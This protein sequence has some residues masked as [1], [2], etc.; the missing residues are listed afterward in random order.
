MNGYKRKRIRESALILMGALERM[1]KVYEEEQAVLDSIPCSEEYESELDNQTEIVGKLEDAI[2]RLEEALETLSDAGFCD[3]PA[4]KS[5]AVVAPIS[6]P[7]AKPDCKVDSAPA[8]SEAPISPTP[9]KEEG[10]GCIG[11]LMAIALPL[12]FAG[13]LTALLFTAYQNGGDFIYLLMIF[14]IFVVYIAFV[15]LLAQ[16][17]KEPLKSSSPGK[18][19]YVTPSYRDERDD[20]QAAAFMGGMLGGYFLGKHIGKNNKS[21][22]EKWRD[23]IFWQE[24]Y[25][26]N[27]HYDDGKDW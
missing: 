22:S 10:I 27:D 13:P 9:A 18:R 23:D 6:V 8:A 4:G 15:R 19:T 1:R 5:A 26:R 16:K 25:R 20:D 11:W 21:F 2:S 17:F 3:V 12:I 14:P 24:K 7:L